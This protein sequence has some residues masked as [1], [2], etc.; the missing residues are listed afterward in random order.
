MPVYQEERLWKGEGR[1]RRE[2][3]GERERATNRHR[4]KEREESEHEK[5]TE[6]ARQKGERKV[7]RRGNSGG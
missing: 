1:M 5:G 6:G 7:E 2:R 3:V 4:E